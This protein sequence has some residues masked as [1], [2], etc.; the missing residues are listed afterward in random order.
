[1]RPMA[2][3]MLCE[4]GLRFVAAIADLFF[5]GLTKVAESRS[6]DSQIKPCSTSYGSAQITP[7]FRPFR[8]TTFVAAS[9][10]TCLTLARTFQRRN[11]S[12]AI[13][14]S[15]RRR[16]TIGVG[17]R[18]RGR[19]RSY[20]TSRIYGAFNR[21]QRQR[22]EHLAISSRMLIATAPIDDPFTGRSKMRFRAPVRVSP[23]FERK[24]PS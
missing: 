22:R 15:K 18:P 20:C 4:T 9:L 10:V 6:A 1:M 24:A 13:L 8:R 19:R 2:R 7:A 5:A 16:V 21:T 11:A 12:Q 3:L 23:K 14:T 17:R